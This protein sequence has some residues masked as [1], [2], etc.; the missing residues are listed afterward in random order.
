[1]KTLF[2]SEVSSNHSQNLERCFKFIDK[3]AEIGCDAVKFQLFK[4]ESLFAPEILARSQIHRD[5]KKWEL[6][7]AFLPD[8]AKRC[9][10][11]NIMFACTPFY[12][13]AV[14][15]LFPYVSFYKIA[16]YELTWPALL[17]QTAQTGKPIV[18]SVGMATL[19]EIKK[20]VEVLKV[21]G[22]QDL[23]LLHCISGYPAPVEECNLLAIETIAKAFNCKV[24]WSDHSVN[25]GVI[26]R[27]VNRYQAAMIE[28][29]LDLDGKGDEFKTGHCWL[30]KPIAEVIKN[31]KDGWVAD[32]NGIKKPTKAEQDEVNQRADPVDGLRPFRHVREAW[33]M[34]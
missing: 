29:H 30:P 5:R 3:S 12:L 13:E 18:L 9:K 23:T 7:V 16:S 17:A 32:G 10:D 31:I 14:E 25:A 22:C 26:Y 20:A 21:N 15:E 19:D 1:M 11:N 6:P 24:G 27:A 28:F 34:K 4:I 8:L 2:V 33:K